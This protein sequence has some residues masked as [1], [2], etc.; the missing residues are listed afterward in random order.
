AGSRRSPTCSA[1]SGWCAMC[2]PG[3]TCTSAATSRPAATST[4]FGAQLAEIHHRNPDPQERPPMK[5][6]LSR[7]LL[8]AAALLLA[9][10][11]QAQDKFTYM[12]NWYAQAEHGGFYQAVATG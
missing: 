3:A 8:A 9:A 2:R 7:P 4:A 11:A 1:C 10:G 6:L 5:S 12:T